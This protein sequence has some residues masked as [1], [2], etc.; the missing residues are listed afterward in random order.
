[1]Q[2]SVLRIELDNFKSYRG[3]QV[4]GPFLHPF[5][6]IIGPNGSGMPASAFE[7]H[8]RHPRVLSRLFFPE[9]FFAGF[10]VARVPCLTLSSLQSLDCGSENA[11]FFRPYKS[12]RGPFLLLLR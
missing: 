2:Q 10:F 12:S 5:V 7:V 4:V 8:S 9:L 6:S 3:Q 1:M 11:W